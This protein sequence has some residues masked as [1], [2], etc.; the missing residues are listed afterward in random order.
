VN[1]VWVYSHWGPH[2][3]KLSELANPG[4]PLEIP[5]EYQY[6]VVIA[7]EMEYN[8]VRRSPAVAPS[9]DL[10]Y[11]KMAFVA[12]SVAEFVRLLG[13]RAI[14]T[15]NDTALSIPLAVD[16]GLG[17]LARNGLLI[18]EGYGP[19]VRLCK[20]LTD[21]PLEPDKPVD[22]GVQHFCDSCKRCA[23]GCP[24]RAILDGERTAEPRNISTSA[25]V[26]KWPIDAERCLAW[27]VRNGTWC[28]NCIRACP[29]NKPAGV[30]H[31]AVRGVV[32]RTSLFDTTFVKTD[33]LLGYGRQ[34]V[35]QTPS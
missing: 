20:V 12:T 11:S 33:D 10:G 24:A 19:R 5:E 2:T 31:K 4:D 21:L 30:S 15:G 9:T 16:A 29:W 26:L 25:G 3:A 34:F 8:D 32:A 18:T 17:E 23:D 7:T 14:P 22:L 28:T 1:R 27:C 13:Y 35:E 6:A